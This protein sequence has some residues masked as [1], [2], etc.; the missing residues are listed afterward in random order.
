VEKTTNAA[1]P[2]KRP[3]C[4]RSLVA[5]SR[6]DCGIIRDE[7][8]FGTMFGRMDFG[9][10]AEGDVVD[11][12]DMEGTGRIEAGSAVVDRFV[13]EY[14]GFGR[15]DGDG[16]TVEVSGREVEEPILLGM[17]RNCWLSYMVLV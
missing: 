11:G 10:C 14:R 9:V 13:A 5:G 16:M 8:D 6:S 7:E 4:R 3:A 2:K 17:L 1:P 12:S 15:Q